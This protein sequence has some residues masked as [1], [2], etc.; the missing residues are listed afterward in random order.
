MEAGCFGAI[1]L[2]F[3]VVAF[4]IALK[5]N[6]RVAAL[7]GELERQQ[8]TLEYLGKRLSD[9]RVEFK[10]SRSGETTAAAPPSGAPA[11]PEPLPFRVVVQ[12]PEPEP[13][14]VAVPE[15]TPIAA[16]SI[17]Q[18][19]P[20]EPPPHVYEPPP[21]PP[22][23]PPPPP[24][25]RAFDWEGLIGVKLFSWIAG[26][27]LVLAALFFLRYSVEQGWLSPIVRCSI[28][29]ITGIV[30]I[31]VCELKI[32][33]DYTTTAN[34]MHGAAI[35]ILF[36]TFFAAHALWHLVPAGVVFA[37]MV[38]V[39]AVAVL[40]SIRR[41]SVFIALLGLV[42]GF[43]T[44][45]LLSSGENRPIGLFSYLLLLNAG[46]AWVAYRKRWP[47]LTALSL[48][49]TVLYQWGWTAK[50]LNAAQLPLAAA[51][52]AMFAVVA[53]SS[54]WIRRTLDDRRQLLFDRI[55]LAGAALPLIFAIFTAAVPA[56]G[57]RYN[58]LFGFL[59]FL[60]AGLAIIG[61]TRG[62][63]WLH[64]LGGI[65]TLLTF[66]IWFSR[67]YH[68]R[69]WPGVL[70]WIAAFVLLFLGAD[71]L[72]AR[73]NVAYNGANATAAAF[74]SLLLFTI[75]TLI[76]IEPRTVVPG[77]T[78]GVLFAL[79]LAISAFAI[80]RDSGSTYFIAA[81]FALA[82]EAVWSSKHLTH[83]RVLT[84]LV[85]YFLF[86][87]FFLGVPLLARRLGH[88]LEPRNGVAIV[89]MVSIALLFFLAGGA[90]ANASLWG[91][92]LLLGIL[93]AGALL[94]ARQRANALIGLAAALL[95]WIVLA[96]WWG[97]A[98]IVLQLI[99]ALTV[100]TGF[101]LLVIGGHIWASRNQ[102]NADELSGGVWLGLAGHVFLFYIATQR[103]L[104]IPP[105]PLLAVLFVLDLALGAAALYLRR[106][107][108]W[109]GA[110]GASQLVLLVFAGTTQTGWAT[111]SIV[112]TIAVAAMALGWIV[113]ARRR[114][115]E[116]Q[117]FVAAAAMA[118][119]AAQLV[120]SVAQSS[121]HP[122]IVTAQMIILV[123]IMALAAYTE[124]HIL[125]PI[126]IVLTVVAVGALKV[127][128]DHLALQRFPLVAFPY[129]AF[130]AYPL[131]IGK[132]AKQS[133]APYLAAVLA[134]IPFFLFTKDV[135]NEEHLNY[136]AGML[137]LFQ[138]LLMVALLLRLLRIEPPS[139]RTLNRLALVAA[140]ALAFVTLAI[141]LQ[142]EKQ[143]ITIGWA[144]EGAALVW[145]F[146]RIPHRGLLVWAGA[147][148]AAVLIRLTVNPAIWLYH[149]P[150]AMKVINWYLY[151]YLVAAAAFFAAAYFFPRDERARMPFVLPALNGSGAVLLF[152]LLNIEIADFY[153]TGPT[154]TFNFFSSSL[155]QDLT[156][157]MGWAA[158]A[159]AMLII[160]IVMRSRGARVAALILLVITILKC[161]LHDLGRL[162]GL[163][164]VVSL[165]GLAMSL[166]LVGILLQKFVMMRPR[167]KEA[168]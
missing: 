134:S 87:V 105:W 165:L 167:E 64:L 14:P 76:L 81:F 45:A 20:V 100:I 6:N 35:A 153:S 168:S 140:A 146:T 67:S 66:V 85:L 166:V 99:P 154:L 75:P 72:A 1:L 130:I 36:A 37:M 161:F 48:V 113:L 114:G 157:T 103:E 145:L 92:A 164:R 143:W 104:A 139:Q 83:D 46:L 160:G 77:L 155:A 101:G 78:F 112:S 16:A 10:R 54:L 23:T 39:T 151:T 24:P 138:A 74:A 108:L 9:L 22:I 84:A 95:S 43:A 117:P 79:L 102:E 133:L 163:Y 62:P 42:G 28:G 11:P 63:Q 137:P 121:S 91:V 31:V 17:E 60:V 149:P 18:L 90:V 111:T 158:F 82:A 30:L 128:G 96:V 34:A 150:G 69:A 7:L 86:A 47:H 116:D 12:E 120:V 21:P 110:I 115:A 118:L 56:Y 93:N 144:L 19:P 3:V 53:A 26:V 25:A 124:L 126:A 141:P 159:V 97:S 162:G 107:K 148:L 70:A 88:P 49:F 122:L 131:I 152:F 32:A 57:A 65:T 41:D 27:A 52:F 94:E 71:W 40:L 50:F 132:R 44:P 142:L 51:V 135:F 136:A 109:V 127:T 5:A 129:A 4:A 15:M 38:L 13:E 8:R 125:V 80:V 156:Y 119:F 98:S 2:I 59:F 73:F 29:V 61:A 147:L 55:G 123:A 89:L 58:V 106:G 33:R 68:E